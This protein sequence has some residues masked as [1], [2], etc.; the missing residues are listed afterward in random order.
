MA[1]NWRPLSTSSDPNVLKQALRDRLRTLL[2]AFEPPPNP[3]DRLKPVLVGGNITIGIGFDL[4]AGGTN[5]Q[6]AVFRALG[7]DVNGTI[8]PSTNT[9]ARQQEDMYIRNLRIACQG[10]NIQAL[11][12]IMQQR[13]NDPILAGVI[14]P[15]GVQ[16]WDKFEFP[17]EAAMNVAF[18]EAIQAYENGLLSRYAFLQGDAAFEYS[19]E[20]AVL[21]SMSWNTGTRP[22]GVLGPKLGQALQNGNR[23]EAWYEIRYNT[24]A[25][26]WRYINS[27]TLKTVPTERGLA[28]R[29]FE[30]AALFGLYND[31]A[32]GVTRQEAEQIYRMLQTHRRE[33]LDYENAYGQ[34]PIANMAVYHG[35]SP[36]GDQIAAART[37]YPTLAGLAQPDPLV[38]TLEPAKNVLLA[39]VFN[40]YSSVLGGLNLNDYLSTAVYLGNANATNNL[41]AVIED[42]EGAEI[43]SK[44]VLIGGDKADYLRGGKGDDVL[45]G[46]G[47]S[48]RLEGGP[49]ADILIGG[50]GQDTYLWRRGEAVAEDMIIDEDGQGFFAFTDSTG[51]LTLIS[52]EFVKDPTDPTRWVDLATGEIFLTNNSPWTIILPDGSTINLGESFDEGDFGIQLLD[53]PTAPQPTL[54]I[55]GDLTPTSG[56]D[57]LGNLNVDPNSPAP[58]RADVLNGRDIET[59]GDLIQSLGG[60]DVV[61]AKAGDDKIEAG[62]GSDIVNAGDGNDL[63][64]GGA[65][66]DLLWGMAGNDRLYADA[67]LDLQTAIAQ[68]E[69]DLPTGT[70]GELLDGGEGE[71]ILVGG[72]GNDALVGGGGT[73]ANVI[74]GGAGD[75]LILGH[76]RIT[77][78]AREWTVTR[79][80]Q[81]GAGGTQYLWGFN[82]ATAEQDSTPSDDALYGGAGNDWLFGG[83]GNDVLDGGS[84]E[85]VLFGA[86]GADVLVGG[87]DRD[88]LVGEQ[89]DDFLAGDIGN[90]T[91]DGGAGS[92]FLEGGGGD[93]V[94]AGESEGVPVA[95]H[96]DDYLDG[97]IG[98]DTLQGYAGADQ[99]F[100]GDNDDRLFGDADTILAAD[101]GNDYLDGGIGND[102]LRGYGG[103]DQL[104][105]GDGVDRLFAEAGDDLLDGGGEDDR[106]EGGIGNDVLI[107]GAG[108]NTLLGG[109]GDDELTGG[110]GNDYL[111][112]DPNFALVADQGNDILDGGAGNDYL[113]GYG[114]TDQLSA[115]DGADQ[116]F[117]DEGADELIGGE[118]NDQLAGGAD[119]DVLE[120]EIGADLL[121]GGPGADVMVGGLDNDTYVVDSITDVVVE[122]ADEGTDTVQS[123]VSYALP[124][125]V[126]N[127]LFTG[128]DAVI[129]TGNEL[130]NVITGTS[131]DDR[132]AGGLGNDTLIGG[133]G[134]DDYV[135]AAGDGQDVIRD[136]G[137][138]DDLNRILFG[139]GIPAGQVAIAR[140]GNDLVL[141]V[142]GTTDQIRVEGW[143]ADRASQ[144]A[145]VQ[146]DDGTVIDLRSLFN[147]APTLTAALADQDATQDEAFEFTVPAGTFADDVWDR[148]TFQATRGDGSALPAWLTFDAETQTFTGTPANDDVGTLAV[149]VRATDAKGLAVSDTFEIAVANV[150]DA[151]VLATPLAD[152][153]APENTPFA[154]TLPPDTFV[155]VDLGD[156]LTYTA[157]QA[158]GSPLPAWL[159]F[160][161]ATRTFQGTPPAGS[162]G[163][164]V[165][166]RVTATDLSGASA[167]GT[168]ALAIGTVLTGTPGDDRLIGSGEADLLQGFA[169]NDRLDGGPGADTLV[170]GEGDDAYVV[171]DPADVIVENPDEGWDT[172]ESSVSY[173]LPDNVENLTLTGTADLNG[174]G[175]DLGNTLIGNAGANRLEGGLLWD[176]LDGGP[177][178][179]TM[180]GGP[181]DDWYFV[182]DPGDVIVEYA[183]EG[184]D[185]VDSSASYALSANLE[186]LRLT[187]MADLS[188][189]GNA[190]D[191]Y[192]EG[193]AGANTL[194]GGPGDDTYVVDRPDDVIVENPGEGYDTVES[195]VSYTLPENVEALNLYLSASATGTGNALDNSLAGGDGDDTLIGGSGNDEYV[196]YGDYPQL[197]F[198]HDVIR[199]NGS[200]ADQDSILFYGIDSPVRV[201]PRRQGD[202]LVV[203]VEDNPWSDVRVEGHFA[204]PARRVEEIRFGGGT[205]WD[206]A[207]ITAML[208]ADFVFHEDAYPL[209]FEAVPF[210]PGGPGDPLT[211]TA[212][213]A[214]GSPLPSWVSFDPATRT[215]SGTPTD[216]DS[217]WYWLYYAVT[218]SYWDVKTFIQIPVHITTSEEIQALLEPSPDLTA[219]AGS[220]FAIIA[221]ALPQPTGFGGSGLIRTATLADGSPLPTWL[222][223]DPERSTLSGSP[224]AADVGTLSV[225]VTVTNAL[226]QTVEKTFT[227]LAA[228]VND[229]PVLVNP[230]ANQTTT[231]GIPFAFAVPAS[232][233]FD[234]DGDALTYAATLAD[235]SVLPAWLVVDPATGT[236][237]G[238][239]TNA[240]VGT[241]ELTVFASDRGWIPAVSTFLLT[242]EEGNTAPVLATPLADQNALENTPF[243][244]TV[245][246]DAFTDEDP[247]DTLAYTATL[248]DGSAL[249]TWLAFDSVTRT[250]TGTP[251]AGSA[252]TTLPVQVT[253]TDLAGE[254]AADIFDVA[255]GAVR[256]GT[257]GADTLIGSAGPDLLQ[258]LGGNDRLDGK[259]GD[260]TMLGG[261]GNDVYVVSEPGDSVLENASEGTDTV[262]SSLSYTLPAN[263][264]YL[265]LTGTGNLS[266]TGNALNNVLRGNSG[267]NTLTGGLGNDVYIIQ[268]AGDVVVENPAEGTDTIESNVSFALP[269]N[270]EYLTLTGSGNLAGT[271]NALNNVLRGNGGDNTLTGGLGN[272]VYIIQNPGDVVVEQ[273]SEGTDTIESNVSYSLPADVEYLTLTGSG[274]LAGIGNAL[275]NVLRGNSGDNTL[276]GG[277]GND[278]YIIQNAGDMVV[279]APSEGT[280]TIES[281]VSF[282]LPDNVEYLTLT[283]TGPLSG[284]GNSLN[285]VLRGNSGDN[286]L[287]GGAGNDVY[288]IQN[289]GDVVVEQPSE[290]TDTVE[291]SVSF[292]L[293]TNVEYLTLTG[294]GNLSGTG[295]TVDNVLR[296]NPGDNTLEGGVGDDV[297]EGKAG[298]DTYLYARGDGQD[299]VT[300]DAGSEHVQFGAE[301]AHDQVW[302]R[303]VADDLEVSLIGTS[304]RATIASWYADPTYHIE[305]FTTTEGKQLLD[306]QVDQLVEAMASFAP[307]PPGQTTLPQ[308]YRDAL[309]PVLAASWQ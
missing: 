145:E 9:A 4:K 124:S 239:P 217:G 66:L 43:A 299:Q 76:V 85:D 144:V 27:G 292:A 57:E 62:T 149:T 98:N 78:A 263:V 93:D 37:D 267:D 289:A 246:A 29:R 119:D 172:V 157:T 14:S 77:T 13:A 126:E 33:I 11:Y 306:S 125:N 56:E 270:V 81:Q 287:T 123:A 262:E 138:A 69:T 216:A 34:L 168:F 68:G 221:Q 184:W 101:Q 253:A 24:N 15:P 305:R 22:G 232:T 31:L 238:T 55:V 26:G 169:G 64:L 235:G 192:L 303:R 63:V 220:P 165:P 206:E 205:V 91:L 237:M 201:R 266:G 103:N 23:A 248:A 7:L 87:A 202:D 121:D 300:D 35:R 36:R 223:F 265:T 269:T 224:T 135:F 240:D 79:T 296:G 60:D 5:I 71:D 127:V 151:P 183:D 142:S 193:N 230:L 283:G 137:T 32:N 191:N 97:G 301:I 1:L 302:F 21:L 190:L 74:L 25:E 8:I 171:D 249:P 162:T 51:K 18:D 304:D 108:S 250:F 30:E 254:S 83:Q 3:Q 111:L 261:L 241:L 210:L 107:G 175:N 105:G 109:G 252:G 46:G 228:N 186:Y 100:G 159:S 179:D 286:T 155:D 16:P 284:T 236:F 132:L 282:A 110:E 279:E 70:K 170:G 277:A 89:G 140:E 245:P 50:S 52:G 42:Q 117:G 40:D 187:G 259:A 39:Y 234:E 204:D 122:N 128:T 131:G 48:D 154:F 113:R 177:G 307:P 10:Q 120:G 166:V 185:T 73:G 115:G 294:S 72:P 207:T 226:G 229:A 271:G 147:Q 308:D 47:G 257:G 6:N 17:S 136:G 203:E 148:L 244:A 181:D 106:L 194:A 112:G 116:L 309:A 260:D 156:A 54:T 118:G 225:R 174:T 233:F 67:E 20:K 295:N 281:N 197:S 227:I 164:T 213:Q 146:F 38:N 49:G 293:P 45:I 96:G 61:A 152:R 196:Y 143:F 65:D 161:P 297:L 150:N 173:A 158:D 58:D 298:N 153:S 272:D 255:V 231:A 278:V 86:Q 178:A 2:D 247:G 275:N 95:E 28:K 198:G 273:P 75:D 139:P 290:G 215:F 92:D 88:V 160:A 133:A 208:N 41:D 188:G 102:Y 134:N 80:V 251:P 280:D 130:D 264:E 189:T 200:A 195:S 291:S 141:A 19:M 104:L 214:D 268:N 12:N 274:N 212:T 53:A 276:T 99:L 242:V 222:T 256:G 285:N 243:T 82:N 84:G 209:E 180:L 176:T 90:D 218:N 258:G 288:I 59:E 182:D 129:A 219:T 114:G 199:D 211:Y 163:T 94:L 44:D 167:T